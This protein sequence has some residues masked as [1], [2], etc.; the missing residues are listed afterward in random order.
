M[1]SIVVGSL[2]LL[3][4]NSYTLSLTNDSNR[5]LQNSETTQNITAIKKVI[6]NDFIKIG[7][8]I[9]QQKDAVVIASQNAISFVGDMDNDSTIELVTYSLSDSTSAS[10][11][12]NQND[13]F[14]QRS[15]NNGQNVVIATGVTQFSLEYL[16]FPRGNNTT[17]LEDIK[18]INITL[19]IQSAEPV[20]DVYSSI[21]W[22]TRISPPN[23]RRY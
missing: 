7:L 17:N 16:D 21:T 22:N 14:L 9:N 2:F 10:Y 5:I 8:G 19:E 12:M 1:A 15:I 20:D 11:T 18:T 13:R 6:Y 4:I 3:S 23:L